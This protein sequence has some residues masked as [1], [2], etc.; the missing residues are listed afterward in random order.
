[1]RIAI[2]GVSPSLLEHGTRTIIEYKTDVSSCRAVLVTSSGAFYDA[3]RVAKQFL[4][5][6]I[7]IFSSC[8]F[9]GERECLFDKFVSSAVGGG[10]IILSITIA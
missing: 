4:Y 2:V 8:D 5:I 7:H 9:I 3:T 10:K 1:M 6:L